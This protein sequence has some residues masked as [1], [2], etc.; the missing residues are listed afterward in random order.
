MGLFGLVVLT[1]TA[2]QLGWSVTRGFN[3]AMQPEDWTADK[4]KTITE[5]IWQR[6]SVLSG[7]GLHVDPATVASR[8]A[9]RMDDQDSVE[10]VNRGR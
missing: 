1:V 7:L 3:E 5:Q 8:S 9:R 4:L 2:A 6:R 10:R